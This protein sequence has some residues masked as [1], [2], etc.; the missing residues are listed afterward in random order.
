MEDMFV[1]YLIPKLLYKLPRHYFLAWWLS[2]KMSADFRLTGI[3]RSR[4][5]HFLINLPGISQN[6]TTFK[7]YRIIV[8]YWIRKLTGKSASFI[9]RFTL[10]NSVAFISQGL[11]FVCVRKPY[12]TKLVRMDFY[13]FWTLVEWEI[14]YP[15]QPYDP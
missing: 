10:L 7:I 11:H 13:N 8:L 3:V 6:A 5:C 2:G 12:D 9:S 15:P 14:N 4:S 1:L